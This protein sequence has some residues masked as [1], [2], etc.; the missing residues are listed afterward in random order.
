MK[1]HVIDFAEPGNWAAQMRGDVLF[2]CLGSTLKD[3]GSQDAQWQIDCKRP[4][5]YT[6]QRLHTPKQVPT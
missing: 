6:V 3:A 2:A 5:I 1:A 4:A